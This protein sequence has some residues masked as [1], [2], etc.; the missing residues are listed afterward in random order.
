MTE[1]H[2]L[3]WLAE[4]S[5]VEESPE[6]RIF[7]INIYSYDLWYLSVNPAT[8]VSYFGVIL[9]Y[10]FFGFV[11]KSIQKLLRKIVFPNSKKKKAGKFWPIHLTTLSLCRR[12]NTAVGNLLLLSFRVCLWVSF[13]WTSGAAARTPHFYWRP[14]PRGDDSVLEQWPPSSRARG[15]LQSNQES[16]KWVLHNAWLN[17][18]ATSLPH[19]SDLVSFINLVSQLSV[20]MDR[21]HFSPFKVK[22]HLPGLLTA[23]AGLSR[24]QQGERSLFPQ[25][26]DTL[27]WLH[28]IKRGCWSLVMTQISFFWQSFKVFPDAHKAVVTC[29]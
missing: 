6:A 1:A 21:F 16:P 25:R 3:V 26:T 8:S 28:L 14:V 15:E 4:S 19:W 29:K 18:N 7:E 20:L 12:A 27:W 13:T 10:I 9:V 23:T 11:Y 24:P 2:W 22:G 17:L 5:S